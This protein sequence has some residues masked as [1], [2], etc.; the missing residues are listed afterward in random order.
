LKKLILSF[1]AVLFASPVFA[2]DSLTVEEAFG[3][4]VGDYKVL[5]CGG[6]LRLNDYPRAKL[7]TCHY[8]NLTIKI[9]DDEGVGPVLAERLS[10][11]PE[12]AGAEYTINAVWTTGCTLST[13][14]SHCKADYGFVD[15]SMAQIGDLYFY[16]FNEA[17]SGTNPPEFSQNTLV[18]QKK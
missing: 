3:K 17:V 10:G 12:D 14:Q 5:G 13:G 11:L 15:V 4:F 18:L 1:V 2:A 16:T 7:K 6:S 9:S 8:A